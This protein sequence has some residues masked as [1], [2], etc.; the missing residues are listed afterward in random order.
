MSFRCMIRFLLTAI[1]VYFAYLW[2]TL[3]R[4]NGRQSV[5]RYVVRFVQSLVQINTS[6]RHFEMS[7][8]SH[9]RKK[10][11]ALLETTL[12]TTSGNG[13]C[14]FPY[15]QV[16]T[17]GSMTRNTRPRPLRRL[18]GA[19]GSF[20]CILWSK[21]LQYILHL[22]ILCTQMALGNTKSI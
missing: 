5:E 16:T 20:L 1:F 19:I 17:W 13:C 15:C 12:L 8:L 22:G 11:T 4:P 18:N 3:Y 9:W 2:S 14:P 21:K 6:V 7:T 10:K